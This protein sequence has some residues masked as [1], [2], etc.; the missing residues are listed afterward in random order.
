MG[1]AAVHL[2][3][4]GAEDTRPGGADGVAERD[5]AAVDVDPV[6]VPADIAVH[7]NGLGR[8]GLVGLDKVEVLTFQPAFSR[9]RRVAGM[10]PVPMMAGSTPA[11]A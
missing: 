11:L 7:R 5:G 3:K 8:K 1:I 2:V 6:E 4:E 9:Q 10:G